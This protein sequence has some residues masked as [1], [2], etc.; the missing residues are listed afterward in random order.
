MKSGKRSPR[1]LP[2]VRYIIN[3][4]FLPFS[5]KIKHSKS[6][7]FFLFGEEVAM[8]SPCVRYIINTFFCTKSAKMK[9]PHR[10]LKQ[11]HDRLGKSPFAQTSF[12]TKNA[13]YISFF[14]EIKTIM[15]GTYYKGVPSSAIPHRRALCKRRRSPCLHSSARPRVGAQWQPHGYSPQA[16]YL[17][18]FPIISYIR[19][20]VN[21]SPH[22]SLLYISF[23]VLF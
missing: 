22:V 19:G 10:V 16:T 8:G 3:E 20:P 7:V 11:R 6:S 17:S 18:P 14:L 4:F 9:H 1:G 21:T 12:T 2:L 5:A 23:F 15:Q 13:Y